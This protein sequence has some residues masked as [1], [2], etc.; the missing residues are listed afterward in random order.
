MPLTGYHGIICGGTCLLQRTPMS[1]HNRTK[2][3]D[4]FQFR[5]PKIQVPPNK[6]EVEKARRYIS[7]LFFIQLYIL[8]SPG[9]HATSFREFYIRETAADAGST[10][11]QNSR[12]QP[13]NRGGTRH[14]RRYPRKRSSILFTWE[15]IVL[16]H[17]FVVLARDFV[18][19]QTIGVPPPGFILSPSLWNGKN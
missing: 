13:T 4:K 16:L 12:S 5:E 19:L 18:T 14:L 2:C 11:G 15:Q 3:H 6:P 1:T 9:V 10:R 17:D 7:L 8:D